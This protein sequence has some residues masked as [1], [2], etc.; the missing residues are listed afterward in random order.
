MGEQ[1]N[2]IE[3]SNPRKCDRNL[4]YWR[5]NIHVQNKAIY[6]SLHSYTALN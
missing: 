5:K 4:E 3:G 1:A 6:S 2:L